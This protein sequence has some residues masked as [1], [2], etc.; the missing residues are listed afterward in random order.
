MRLCA[1]P[2]LPGQDMN[3]SQ[4]IADVTTAFLHDAVPGAS[5]TPAEGT[6]RFLLDGLGPQHVAAIARTI[7]ADPTLY[8]KLDVRLPR[9]LGLELPD[10]LLT[11]KPATYWRTA[12]SP[13][14]ALLFATSS[15]DEKQ[16]L[17]EVA[18]IGAAELLAHPQLWVKIAS[19]GLDLTQEQQIWWEKALN[20]LQSIRTFS[21]EQHAAYVVA[22]YAAVHDEGQPLLGALGAALPAL[23][24]P[25]DTSY[26]NGI[27]EKLRR[28]TSEWKK[29]YE[30]MQ[31]R[32]ACFLRKR[33]PSQTVL[34]EED[35]EKAF[36]RVTD[37]IQQQHHE[38]VRAFIK[39]PSGWNEQSAALADLEWES[40]KPLFDGLKREKFNLGQATLAFFDDREPRLTLPATDKE[41]LERLVARATTEAKDEDNDFFNVHRDELRDDPKL[42]SFWDRFVHGKPAETSDFMRGLAAALEVLFDQDA[43]SVRRTLRIRCD[44]KTKKEFKELNVD[45][46]L[47]F[48]RRYGG[49][50]QLLGDVAWDVGALFEF[51]EIEHEWREK[52]IP[53]NRSHA[54]GSLQLRFL[55]ELEAELPNGGSELYTAHLV[56]KFEPNS[57]VSEFYDD[58]SRLAEHPFGLCRGARDVSGANGSRSV[59]LGNTKTFVPVYARDRGSFVPAY[60]ASDD[61]ALHWRTNLDEARSLGLLSAAAAQNLGTCFSGFCDSYG[62]AL[63]GFVEEG[64]ACGALREQLTKFSV[65]LDTIC[66]QA[67]GDRNRELLLKP[68]LQIGTV[69][70]EGTDAAVVVAPWHPLRIAAMAE[71]ADLLARLVRHLLSAERVF[72]GDPRL[73]FKD[74][75]HDLSHAFYPEVVVG[76]VQ[77]KAELVALSDVVHDYSLHEPPV[78]RDAAADDTNENPSEGSA[79]VA[80][81]LERYTAL[82]PHER[83][84]LSLVLFNCDSAR[85]PQAVVERLSS[86]HDG[87][88]DVRCHVLLRHVDAHRLR[89]V[90]TDIIRGSGADSDAYNPSEA[91]QDFMARLRIGII[92]DVRPP[93]DPREGRPYDLVF[94]QDVIARHAELA[95]YEV[96]AEPFSPQD[97]VPGRW[98]RR[99]PAALDD[100]KS[101]VF[102]CCPAQTAAGWA[103]LTAIST[104]FKGDWNE[105]TKTRLLPARQLNFRDP[106]TSKI[107]DETHDL[108]NWVVNYDDLLD[109]RQLLNRQVRIIRYKQSATQGRNV[110]ISSKASL[111]L[112][113][114]TVIN[115]LENLGL[116]L[117]GTELRDLV[118]RL[119]SDAADISGDIVLR[120][121]KRGYHA[122]ELLGLVLS[123]FLLRRE[124]GAGRYVGWYFLDDYAEWLGQREEQIADILA[125][126][127]TQDDEGNL[128][129]DILL[130]E[131]KYITADLLSA[132]KKESQKQLRD[133]MRRVAD[134]VFGDPERLDRGLWLARL[135]DLILDGVQFPAS[136]GIDLAAWRRAI[137][138]GRCAIR[139]RGYSHV[140][141][142]GPS[143]AADCA[144]F[145][146]VPGLDGAFQEVFG[147]SE[148]RELVLRFFRDEDP[149]SVRLRVAQ[150]DVWTGGAYR[151]PTGSTAAQRISLGGFVQPTI[152]SQPAA[153]IIADE[154][155]RDEGLMEAQP[156]AET[157]PDAVWAWPGVPALLEGGTTADGEAELEWLKKVEAKTKSALQQF[158]LQAKVIK[159]TLTPNT[160][161]LRFAGT[162]NLTVD[163]V[164]KRRSELLTTFGLPIVAVQPEA[165]AVCVAV[166]RE[167]RRVVRIQDVWGR[168]RPKSD[169]G[170]SELAIGVREADGEL[171]FL[172]PA[173]RHAPHTLIAGSTGSGKSVLMQ[174]IILGIAA[175]NSPAQARITLIDPKLGVDYF[176]FEGLPHLTDGI[177]DEQGVA[178]QRLRA[179][180]DEMDSRYRD[181]FKPARAANLAAYNAKVAVEDRLPF[182]WLIHDEFAEWMMIEDYKTEVTSLVSRLGV[183]ARAAGIHLI[184]AAQR[185]DANVMPMQLRANLGNRLILRVDS[186]GTSEIALGE[187]GAERLLG[188]GHLL[189][190]LD[191]EP[192][193]AYA[194]VPLSEPGFIERVVQLMLPA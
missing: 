88:E 57:V 49:I 190:R 56:W 37:T 191:G 55:L 102:L 77:G 180:V 73:F 165:G 109:R 63:R 131:A 164:L 12:A 150:Q 97:L 133:T 108:G 42:K 157:L 66:R 47:Y 78:L 111:G 155:Q 81:L 4:L 152:A 11:D 126:S 138:E 27:K 51:E 61:V 87:D 159:S 110:V 130:S 29:Q 70:V 187:V 45:A 151:L 62:A 33:T 101:A 178:L 125:L 171:L 123:R 40:I 30:S 13:R 91:T 160:A 135:S 181:R 74:L 148:V 6:S 142:P 46:G 104:L 92:A 96:D 193:L 153:A 26:F 185:P 114:T 14:P 50:K 75:A 39:A 182:I 82:Q 140:F 2:L 168:W 54:R 52:K 167:A 103:F 43:Q 194:Q 20:G 16:S 95:W 31:K 166:A 71:K 8:P 179:L 19:S 116:P 115:R 76:W 158:N 113:R 80:E 58:W 106:R 22:T 188:R 122:N 3:V 137:R 176:E 156:A 28:Q 119:I 85:L 53:L 128:R 105:N 5:W 94:L 24:L 175:T 154:P 68:L 143:D 90:Y 69:S 132:K 18:R 186:E 64:L 120:A 183:K 65:L 84:N 129:L 35:L 9:R 79:C 184:F 99:R 170:N 10:E 173:A 146:P 59:N 38:A 44:R 15:D 139:L 163:Q 98:S 72:F 23:K 107:F 7:L 145:G 41:Y 86:M 17:A 141:V 144:E 149:A 21:L 189:A 25:R 147:R 172:S 177:I 1:K 136:S 124:I 169:G 48:A 60:K 93:P 162:A 127:P 36:T 34:S 192:T 32:R 117:S 83:A 121:A 118:D 174:N 67:K 112:L 100:M 89:D 134:A 161:L